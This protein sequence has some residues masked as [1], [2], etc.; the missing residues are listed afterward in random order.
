MPTN[1][2]PQAHINKI[3]KSSPKDS[4]EM[5]LVDLFKGMTIE[6]QDII[7]SLA[8]RFY[9]QNNPEDK[10]AKPFRE[11]PKKETQ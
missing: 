1:A 3:I 11:R 4:R 8:N 5:Q 9:S 10:T 2:S 6:D 7:L